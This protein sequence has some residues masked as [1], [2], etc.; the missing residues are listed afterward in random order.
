MH[1]VPGIDDTPGFWDSH[2]AWWEYWG[3]LIDGASVWE[4]AWPE[5]HGTIEGDLSRDIKVMGPLQEN[6][7]TFMMRMSLSGYLPPRLLTSS[8]YQYA[9][10]Q[11][12]RESSINTEPQDRY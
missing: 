5:V 3:D 9:S 2:P 7:K 1:F 10:V 8:S 11:E 12:C 6:G 4:S